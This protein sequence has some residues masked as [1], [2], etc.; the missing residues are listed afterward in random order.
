MGERRRSR[1]EMSL[2]LF[3]LFSTALA[4]P[5]P[6]PPM[7]PMVMDCGEGMISCPGD[8]DPMGCMMP[9]ICMPDGE[10][11]PFFCPHM[12]PMDCGEGM[13][14]CPGPIDPMGCMMPETCAAEGDECPFHC[15][16]PMPPM[17]CGEG[18]SNCPGEVDPM[19][20][21]MPEI[22]MPYGEA[23]PVPM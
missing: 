5:A 21:M 13:I 8:I 4:V 12:P 16:P 6:C 17:D 19:G 14:S 2:L 3:T 7:P 11:C 9:E 15:P 10:A 23:C 18:M 22:C 20:C 1:F